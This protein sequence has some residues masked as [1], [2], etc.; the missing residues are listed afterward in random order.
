MT[1]TIRCPICDRVLV[2]HYQG[3]GR[4]YYDCDIGH[5]SQYGHMSG[6]SNTIDGE[7]FYFNNIDSRY[8][9]IKENNKSTEILTN[10][11]IRKSKEK[12][13]SDNDSREKF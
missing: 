2:L 7:T 10:E 4:G 8:P 13:H 12:Y 1:Y 3:H 11:A 9:E 6:W 5:Y